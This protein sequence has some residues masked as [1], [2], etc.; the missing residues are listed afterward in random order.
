MSSKANLFG[1]A[2]F[3]A[4]FPIQRTAN[5][6]YTVLTYPQLCVDNVYC[7]DIVVD[8]YKFFFV[9]IMSAQFKNYLARCSYDSASDSHNSEAQFVYTVLYPRFRQAN[10]TKQI[11]YCISDTIN[12]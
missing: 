6:P 7:S 12:L 5:K 10:P 8:F 3:I 9:W 1:C 2:E 4:K 11:Q